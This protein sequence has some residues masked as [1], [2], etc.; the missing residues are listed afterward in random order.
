[1]AIPDAQSIMLPLL[2]LAGD[3]N[4]HQLREASTFWL[5]AFGSRTTRGAIALP[6][7]SHRGSTTV[8]FLRVST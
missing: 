3:S 6:M 8:S 5:I 1:M 4:I 2:E 7:V